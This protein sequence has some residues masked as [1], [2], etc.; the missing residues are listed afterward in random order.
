MMA[1]KQL[2]LAFWRERRK[3]RN[4]GNITDPNSKRC[5]NTKLKQVYHHKWWTKSNLLVDA[6]HNLSGRLKT[7]TNKL[8]NRS[9][10]HKRDW[11]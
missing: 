8:I 2:S 11:P 1:R 5:R 3:S 10:K 6:F 7:P 9:N 4:N